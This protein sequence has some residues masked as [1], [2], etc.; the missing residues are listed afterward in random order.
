V[1]D[2]SRARLRTVARSA[3]TGSS[4][5]AR[6][7]A[8]RVGSMQSTTTTVLARITGTNRSRSHT[9]ARRD[10]SPVHRT[11]MRLRTP[12]PRPLRHTRTRRSRR[13]PRMVTGPI[14]S[15]RPTCTG[16]VTP[17]DPGRP[18]ADTATTATEQTR[19]RDATRAEGLG[20]IGIWRNTECAS[21]TACPETIQTVPC[22]RFR[23]CFTTTST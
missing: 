15:G 18:A 14:R 7:R 3:T 9:V 1:T 2:P 4:A 22:A 17:R 12:R 16:T 19:Q 23:T 8:R 13:R 11:V 5:I 21:P 20:T 6:S 10:R